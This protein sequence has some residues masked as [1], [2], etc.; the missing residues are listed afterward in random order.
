MTWV[1]KDYT[2]SSPSFAYVRESVSTT[3]KGPAISSIPPATSHRQV[4]E[5]IVHLHGAEPREKVNL[6]S[7]L[8]AQAHIQAIKSAEKQNEAIE[9]IMDT[10]M[11]LVE[12]A[13]KRNDSL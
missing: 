1:S 7:T 3:S 5:D 4:T 10:S 11:F 2:C 8:K 9:S 6:V 12:A 13:G